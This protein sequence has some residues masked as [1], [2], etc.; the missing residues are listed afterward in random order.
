MFLE[1]IQ[2]KL[3]ASSREFPWSLPVFA[4][5]DEL[6]FRAPVT[7]LVGE[8][9]SGKSTL[10]E[11]LAL[12][13]KAI[14]AGS[15]DLDLDETLWAAHE[16]AAA[17]RFVRRGHP[18][19][20]MYLRAEDVFGYTLRAARLRKE[21]DQAMN[22][23]F[24]AEKAAERD[25]ESGEDT[26]QS[27]T[28]GQRLK[29]KLTSKYGLDPVAKS[30]GETFFE[31]LQDRL[32]PQGLYFLDEP[33]APMSPTRVLALLSLIMERA[34]KACQFVVATHSPIL[35]ALPKAEILLLDGDAIGPVA[36]EELEHVSVTKAFLNNPSRFLRRL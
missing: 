5:L 29:T 13:V 28:G 15:Q 1:R 34:K 35:M 23:G 7:F 30:H 22:S 36:Y 16:F 33:E 27:L 19:R 32:V 24:A 10:L 31:M 6:E 8:N 3:P 11:G 4:G 21:S 25:E 9:G 2:R 17:F 26:E 14:A 12:G 20:T 18:R